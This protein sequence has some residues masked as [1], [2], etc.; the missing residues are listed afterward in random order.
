MLCKSTAQEEAQPSYHNQHMIL[1]LI[2]VHLTYSSE[3]WSR[4]SELSLK[5]TGKIFSHYYM[6]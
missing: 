4:S 3:S 5:K 6:I 2:Y 1:L